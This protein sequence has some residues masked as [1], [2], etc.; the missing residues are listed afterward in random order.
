MLH[1][2]YD[3]FAKK[4]SHL[5]VILQ[6]SGEWIVSF[7]PAFFVACCCRT[8]VKMMINDQGLVS[9]ITS[10]NWS[11]MTVIVN[12]IRITQARGAHFCSKSRTECN[13]ILMISTTPAN[14]YHTLASC[15]SVI[16]YTSHIINW[17]NGSW[18]RFPPGYVHIR[19]KLLR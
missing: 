19:W 8:N 10:N 4:I 18:D 12:H 5:K 11:L 9:E 1:H 16:V 14:K 3:A 7:F 15:Y 13:V 2:N 17:N 6:I